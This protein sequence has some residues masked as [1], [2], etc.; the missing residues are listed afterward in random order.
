MEGDKMK[1][2]VVILF[3]L[4]VAAQ[5]SAVATV[6]CTPVFLAGD[7]GRPLP[8]AVVGVMTEAGIAVTGGIYNDPQGVSPYTF[9]LPPNQILQFFT[10]QAGRYQVLVSAAG[11]SKSYWTICGY[12]STGRVLSIAR[13]AKDLNPN[14]PTS[15]LYAGSSTIGR[16]NAWDFEQGEALTFDFIVPSFTT[17]FSSLLLETMTPQT[18]PGDLACPITWTVNFC[19]YANAGTTCDIT[20]TTNSISQTVTA[21]ATADTRLDVVFSSLNWPALV[22]SAGDHIIISITMSPNASPTACQL[23]VLTHARLELN[24]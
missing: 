19:K 15:A 17:T 6:P 1:P 5:A 11:M 18:S 9:T 8:G 10:D 4:L 14:M 20:A 3:A 22:Y 23:G 24:K 13:E 7:Q 21:P 16:P 2:L 12:G